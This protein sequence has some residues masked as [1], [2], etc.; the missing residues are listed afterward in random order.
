MFVSMVYL[1]VSEQ[2]GEIRL[3]RAGHNPPIIIRSRDKR[4]ELCQTPGV[5]LG[6]RS[7]FGR[8]AMNEATVNLEKGDL[9]VLYSDGIVEAMNSRQEEYGIKRFVKNLTEGSGLPAKGIA[10]LVLSKLSSWRGKAAQS[11]DITLVILKRES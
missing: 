7:G 6:L 1:L 4:P 9:I 5:A 3:V 2:S 10:D 11:D 8:Q